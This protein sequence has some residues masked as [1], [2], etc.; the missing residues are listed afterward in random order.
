METEKKSFHY[1][2]AHYYE[3][4]KQMHLFQ[5][6]YLLIVNYNMHSLTDLLDLTEYRAKMQEEKLVEREVEKSMYLCDVMVMTT[7]ELFKQA[8]SD[9]RAMLFHLEELDYKVGV[10]VYRRVLEKLG[11]QK[12]SMEVYDEFD[13]VY[14]ESVTDKKKDEKERRR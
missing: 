1:K 8:S 13:E 6:E 11:I 4:I 9:I 7:P 5:E 3:A 10:K 12:D 14:K 2:S